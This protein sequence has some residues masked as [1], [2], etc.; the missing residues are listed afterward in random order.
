LRK[1]HDAKV[2]GTA[3]GTEAQALVKKLGAD[4]VI[5]PTSDDAIEQVRKFANGWN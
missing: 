2:I 4:K 5:D 1:R 3:R